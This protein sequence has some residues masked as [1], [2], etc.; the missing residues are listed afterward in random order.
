MSTL[1]DDLTTVLPSG[2]VVTDPDLLAG[3]RHDAASLCE[4]HLPLAAALPADEAQVQA[5]VRIAAEHGVPVVP[6]G[7]LTGL[8]GAANA[9]AGGIVL[10]TRRMNRIVAID[11]TDRLA[12]VQPGVTNREL[13]LSAAEHGLA[14]RP[15]PS[16]WE[17]STIGGNIATD[18]GGLCCVKYGVTRRFVRALRVVLADGRATSVGRRTIKGVAGLSL[19]E[20]FIG[21]EGTLGVITEATVA[22]EPESAAP[23]TLAAT[24]P[25]AAAAGRAVAAV[26]AEGVVPSLFELIDRT[27]LGAIEAHARMGLG[28]AGAL[29]IAQSDAG[30]E[31]PAELRRIAEACTS[32]GALD[33]VVA[34]DQVE[35]DQLVQAR[36]LAYPALEALGPC[37]VDDVAVPVSALATVIDHVE[38]VAASHGLT[39]G[40]VGHAGDGN[41]HPTVVVDPNDPESLVAAHRAFDEIAEF[42][43]TLGGTV[44]GEHGIGLLKVGLLERELDP[45]AAELQRRVKEL[46]DPTYL[47]NP[48]KVLS[49][50]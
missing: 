37:L 43:L 32:A 35:S 28:D 34:D 19:T 2:A 23:L 33:V 36:R 41:L 1:V 11:P 17:S 12:V 20:L 40:V 26:R 6:Q 7:A 49:R 16:S 39:I 30:H 9:V 25:D 13:R 38:K 46:F 22:L 27:V 50:P 21:S 45:V 18:A 47:F 10:N 15:D 5:V 29:L 14:Y 42:A 31:A 4:S 48:G 8:S 44:T 24:F 3:Y